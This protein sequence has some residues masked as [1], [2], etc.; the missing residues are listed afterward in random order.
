M[1]SKVSNLLKGIMFMLLLTFSL[2]IYAQNITVNGVV[3]DVKGEPLIGVTIQVQGTTLGTVTDFDGR[4][5]LSNVPSDATLE[6]TYV[7]MQGQTI[8]VNGRTSLEIVMQEE[9]EILEEVVVVGYGTMKRSSIT[10]SSS[11]IKTEQIE[12]FPVQMSLMPCRDKHQEF[13]SRHHVNLVN[14]LQSELGVAVHYQQG[15]IPY[16]LLMACPVVGIT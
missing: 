2:C 1:K 15:M 8:P 14:P 7:G 10:G 16:S 9:T 6:V 11:S 13:L 4:F 12:T 5:S 3:K